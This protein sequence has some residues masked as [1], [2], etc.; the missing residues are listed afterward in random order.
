MDRSPNVAEA[1]DGRERPCRER[2]SEYLLRSRLGPG[3][4]VQDTLQVHP[5]KL[6]VRHPCLP[7][8]LDGHP[9]SKTL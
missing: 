2:S 5:C 9:G 8:V 1:R 3:M 7:T 4:S 6:G